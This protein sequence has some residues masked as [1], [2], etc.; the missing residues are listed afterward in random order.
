MIFKKGEMHALTASIDMLVNRIA[1]ECCH[2]FVIGI[3]LRQDCYSTQNN[4]MFYC[5]DCSDGIIVT[6][7]TGNSGTKFC[8]KGKLVK[9]GLESLPKQC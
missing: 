7:L 4:S 1:V 9:F 6:L 2:R 3:L 5:P 8:W